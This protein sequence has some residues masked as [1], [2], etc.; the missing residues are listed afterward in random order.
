MPRYAAA[1]NAWERADMSSEFHRCSYIYMNG[2]IPES[3]LSPLFKLL[4]GG[5]LMHIKGNGGSARSGR[6]N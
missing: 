2:M 5:V 1:S 3:Y 6:G 4:C